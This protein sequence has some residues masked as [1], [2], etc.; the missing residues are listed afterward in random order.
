MNEFLWFGDAADAARTIA[1]L[2]S[3][4]TDLKALRAGQ[5]PSAADLER[6]PLLECY[7]LKART[8]CCLTGHVIGHPVLGSHKDINTSQL[9]ALYPKAKWA[10]TLSRWYRLGNSWKPYGA[11]N[12]ALKDLD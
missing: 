9:F 8:V 6:A 4:V 7:Q 3:L 2:E 1:S 5:A 11:G 12:G 10:R